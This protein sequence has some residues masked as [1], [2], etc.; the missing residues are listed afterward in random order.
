[1]F[2][3]Q[4][5]EIAYGIRNLVTIMSKRLRKQMSNPEQLSIAEF[6]VLS[7]LMIQKEAFPSELGAQLS[8]SSQFMSQVL[9]RMESLKYISRKS[10]PSDGRKTLVTLT[11]QGKQKVELSR[12]ER[13]EWLALMVSEKYTQE[14]KD[15]IKKALDLLSAL[16]EL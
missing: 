13:E 4:D 8:I 3:K 1:M 6:N 11:K 14:E 9:N 10:A 15:V 5:E 7:I 2:N 12:R 16:T